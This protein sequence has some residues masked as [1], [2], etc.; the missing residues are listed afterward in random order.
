MPLKIKNLCFLALTL[1]PFMVASCATT[2]ESRLDIHENKG[3]QPHEFTFSDQGKAIYYAFDLSGNKSKIDTLIFF[4]SGSGCS[5]V[6]NRFPNYFFPLNGIPAT[7][8]ILQKRGIIDGQSSENCSADF[9]ETDFFD[10]TLNDQQEFILEKI[11]ETNSTYKNIVIIGAS[12]GSIVASKIA[13]NNSDI[14]HLGL[15]GS[16]GASLRTDLEILSKKQ[17]LFFFTIKWN[18]KAVANDPDSLTKKAWGHS[19]KYWSSILDV[20]LR[21]IL[22]KLDIPIIIAMGEKD[23]SVPVESLEELRKIFREQGKKNLFI[24]IY[25]KANHKLFDK[26]NSIS[27]APEFLQTLRKHITY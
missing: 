6:K 26:T 19:H 23:K 27:Y 2:P 3:L 5:S 14:T 25:P 4:I 1:L 10:Q 18:L 24:N 16:G 7:V 15:I 11:A 8:Y 12:E 13:E 20:D 22:P 17:L 21:E 9:F